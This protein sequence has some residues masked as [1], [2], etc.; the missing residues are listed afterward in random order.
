[1][2]ITVR[3]I[4]ADEIDRVPLRCWPDREAIAGLFARQDTIGI[5]AWDG[6]RCVAQLH[7][8]RIEGP[9]DRLSG[10]PR[11]NRPWFIE[12]VQAGEAEMH[13]PAWCHACCHVGR[14]LQTLHEELLSLVQRFAEQANWSVDSLHQTLNSLDAVFL[15]REE[16]E[17]MV[18]ELHS[19]ERQSFKTEAPEYR[20]QGVGTAL[21]QESIRWAKSHGCAS[22]VGRGVPSGIPEAAAHAGALPWTTYARLGF[23]PG[24]LRLV[25]TDHPPVRQA[26]EAA[27]KAGRSEED[28]CDRMMVLD[29]EGAQARCLPLCGR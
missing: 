20:G 8:Y 23:H 26:K 3:P 6:D 22:V 9:D 2:D 27:L 7:C 25:D 14:T 16:V 5:A 18:G 28:I 15:T 29:M 1:M 12:G 24:L 21:C 10:W 17:S 4:A 11:W 19:A 13:F